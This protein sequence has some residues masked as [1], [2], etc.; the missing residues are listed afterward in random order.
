[1][2]AISGLKKAKIKTPNTATCI[3]QNASILFAKLVCLK[4]ETGK[5]W[6]NQECCISYTSL[7]ALTRVFSMSNSIR[8]FMTLAKIDIVIKRG[9][10]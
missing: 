1:M 3:L 5:F 9:N 8:Y 6:Q 7:V 10:Q 4:L 2:K